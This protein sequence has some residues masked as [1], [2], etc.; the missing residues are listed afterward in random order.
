MVQVSLREPEAA[1]GPETNRSGRV[2]A[3]NKKRGEST[4]P[5]WEQLGCNTGHETRGGVVLVFW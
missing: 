2:G 1:S 3:A 5:D 4:D